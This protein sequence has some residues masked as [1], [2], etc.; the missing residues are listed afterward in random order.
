MSEK[1]AY[2][3]VKTALLLSNMLLMRVTETAV[4]LKTKANLYHLY[5]FYLVF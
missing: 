1:N 2:K 3:P 5:G 4:R